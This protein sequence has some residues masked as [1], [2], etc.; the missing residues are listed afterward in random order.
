MKYDKK[1]FTVFKTT[2]DRARSMIHIQDGV[3]GIYDM[4]ES[5]KDPMEY[6][7]E[8]L[9]A[10]GQLFRYIKSMKE[11]F[12]G[13]FEKAII[14]ETERMEEEVSEIQSKFTSNETILALKKLAEIIQSAKKLHSAPLYQEAIVTSVSAFET[15]LKDRLIDLISQNQVV[16]DRFHPTLRNEMNY[17]KFKAYRQEQNKLAG[18][19]V[20]DS[21][22]FFDLGAVNTTFR[23]ALGLK[24]GAPIIINASQQKRIGKYFQIRHIIVHNN[25][26]I[27]PKF[28]NETKCRNKI[29]NHYPIKRKYV[30]DMIGTI[31]KVV[32]QIE[33][34]IDKNGK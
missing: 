23:N 29:G 13:K 33:E 25:G 34:K 24:K 9:P 26:I 16:E 31:D 27:D 14:T 5:G 15:Y 21:I 3:D 7:C 18:Y 6:I 17:D 12:L 28:K 11:I 1:I 32:T 4:M 10:F 20:A 30:L 19:V 8:K 22:S 2:L